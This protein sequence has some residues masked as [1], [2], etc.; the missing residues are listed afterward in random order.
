M[1]LRDWI[2]QGTAIARL[3]LAIKN[4]RVHHCYIFH[5][6]E[7]VGKAGIAADF[8]RLLLCERPTT[9]PNGEVG[10]PLMGPSDPVP[11]ACGSCDTCRQILAGSHPDVVSVAREP[12]R[13]SVSVSVLNERFLE[14]VHMKSWSNKLKAFVFPEAD[15]IQ[16][17][18]WNKVLKTLEEPPP[19]TLAVLITPTLE[20]ILPTVLSR[21]QVIRF[22]PLPVD[23]VARLLTERHGLPAAEAA[24]WA[25]FTGGSPGEALR[26]AKGGFHKLKC[27]LVRRLSG[28]D[29]AGVFDLAD[30]VMGY[31]RGEAKTAGSESAEG[32]D[33]GDGETAT[34][35]AVR[36]QARQVLGATAAFYR[37]VLLA[38]GGADPSL[39]IHTDQS[40][41]VADGARRCPPDHARRA[42]EAVASADGRIAQFVIPQLAIESLLLSVCPT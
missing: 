20:S 28:L 34:G 35:E 16:E 15:R 41:L 14:R 18:G 42:I 4:D 11:D 27:D 26:R 23:A 3:L 2:G 19:H 17:V 21:A 1:A 9:A 31:A 24:F 6:P 36:T 12:G 29:A 37:D 13:S 5:G 38:H 7:G 22:H 40:D 39:M 30:A 8:V 25:R 10:L 32:S 33:S